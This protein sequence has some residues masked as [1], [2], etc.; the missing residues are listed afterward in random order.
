M[1]HGGTG[2]P[3]VAIRGMDPSAVTG[4]IPGS[5]G[6]VTPRSARSDTNEAYSS[7]EKKN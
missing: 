6:F 4:M 2:A 5:T 3:M 7:M 1:A